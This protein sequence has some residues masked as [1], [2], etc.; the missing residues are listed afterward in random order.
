MHLSVNSG[1]PSWDADPDLSNVTAAAAAEKIG[2]KLND[3]DRKSVNDGQ[4][5]NR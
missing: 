4:T 5:N 2:E 3:I 1:Q